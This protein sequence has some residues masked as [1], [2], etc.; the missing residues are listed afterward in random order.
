MQNQKKR[1]NPNLKGIPI[2]AICGKY[3]EKFD[4]I[5]AASKEF[6]ISFN[7][8]KDCL[9]DGQEYQGIKFKLN[10]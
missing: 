10:K 7:R 5:N 8:I 9:R 4:S 1:G 6:N 2:I 3:K